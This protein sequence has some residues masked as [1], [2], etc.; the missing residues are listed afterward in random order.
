MSDNDAAGSGGGIE[1]DDEL[2]LINTTVSGNEARGVRAATR[3]ASSSRTTRATAAA[4][5]TT[6]TTA[7]TTSQRAARRRRSRPEAPFLRA[8]NSTIAF[9]EAAGNGGG[10]STAVPPEL[11][12]H[13]DGMRS[14]A[15]RR[16]R[17]DRRFQNTI[18]SDNTPTGRT[19]A[20][21]TSPTDAG[22]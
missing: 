1:N 10:V 20:P 21:A 2:T 9:N 11:R 13:S 15:G 8:D 3:S 16:G 17:A 4:S 12:G 22:V 5:T 18:V 7:T 14:A 6:A 19:T